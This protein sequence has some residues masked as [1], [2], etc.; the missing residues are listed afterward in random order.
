MT[1]VND[2]Y[3]AWRVSQKG[4]ELNRSTQRFGRVYLQAS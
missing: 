2:C 3:G 1:L 4:G